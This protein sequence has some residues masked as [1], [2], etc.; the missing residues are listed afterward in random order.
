[1]SP[2]TDAGSFRDPSGFVFTRD[3]IVLRQVND[4][5]KQHYDHLL[6]SGLYDLLV[7][8]GLLVAHDEVGL[9]LAAA[10]PAHRVL[11]PEQLP[12]VSYPYEWSFG[13]LKA[14]ALA[15]LRA[16][17][18]ALDHGMV[19]KDASAYN[20]QF[21]GRTPVLIDTLSFEIRETGRPWVA[22]RQFCQHFLA[23]LA[24][25]SLVDVRLGQLLRVHLDGVP[26]DLARTL[27]PA[28][29][30]LRPGLLVHIAAH[31]RAQRRHAEA[32]SGEGGA[33]GARVSERALRGLV[34]SLVGAVSGLRWDPEPSVWRDYYDGDSYAEEAFAHKLELVKAGLERVRPRSVWD[35]GAN[36]GRFSRLAA[37]AGASTVAFDLDPS[38]VE[39]AFRQLAE[40]GQDG[41]LPL[42]LD[43]TNPSPA[44][45]WHHRE[46]RSLAQR[47]PADLLLALAL[48]HHLAVANN[49]PLPLVA[50]QLRA[51]GSWAI[52]EFVPKA[53][54]KVQTLLTDREDVFDDYHLD[55]FERALA[56]HFR[57][58][59]RTPLRDSERTLYLLEGR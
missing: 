47:A 31:A 14:A 1:M 53:D 55:G 37:D 39:V 21:R 4:R 51:L 59:T 30:S 26:L 11:R 41:V 18:V 19:L 32:R 2:P 27:L 8:E 15:T 56:P 58:E 36:T 50:E 42:V 23:P 49:V 38:A 13:Q 52:V 12:F 28:R 54:P 29:A 44:L 35:L 16:Q 17:S 43:L 33:E 25:M 7:G 57:I 6:T 45:G 20:V 10:P 46:R 22:Y 40:D 34:D 48:V 3:G 24:L 5:Y 9:E